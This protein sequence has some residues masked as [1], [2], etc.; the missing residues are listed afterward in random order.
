[1][2]G[3]TVPLTEQPWDLQQQPIP[4]FGDQ[5]VFLLVPNEENSLFTIVSVPL[6]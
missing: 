1:M 5:D 2:A 3:N 6:E 4:I